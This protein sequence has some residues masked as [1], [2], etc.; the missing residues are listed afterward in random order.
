LLNIIPHPRPPAKEEFKDVQ[1]V[2]SFLGEIMAHYIAPKLNPDERKQ[3]RIYFA[4]FLGDG[5]M[6]GNSQH[7][8][9]AC[10]DIDRHDEPI[11]GQ[12]IIGLANRGKFGAPDWRIGR[13]IPGYASDM[14]PRSMCAMAF[15]KEGAWSM[16]DL[17]RQAES[18]HNY[19]TEDEGAFYVTPVQWRTH[20]GHAS[21]GVLAISGRRPQSITLALQT[22]VDLLANVI[23][24]L[25]SLHAVVNRRNLDC[26]APDIQRNSNLVGI[27]Q[28][29]HGKPGERFVRR[30]VALRRRIAKYFVEG[31]IAQGI[32]V[33]DTETGQ[34]SVKESLSSSASPRKA[35]TP[36]NESKKSAST[37]RDQGSGTPHKAVKVLL[38]NRASVPAK[39]KAARR[40]VTSVANSGPSSRPSTR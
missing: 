30:A 20:E 34:I 26:E 15:H 10:S 40:S 19:D 21:I 22:G 37:V 13:G 32:H 5:I 36:K 28:L 33:Q 31:F 38:K 2:I 27:S 14:H 6:V 7:L 24:Y 3:L 39:P 25:F 8:I 35:T 11:E 4:C 16:P 9:T 12:F 23:G 18:A 17:S 29:I 1:H